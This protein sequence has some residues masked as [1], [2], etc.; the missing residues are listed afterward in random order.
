[1]HLF[2]ALMFFLLFKFALATHFDLSPGATKC[3][4]TELQPESTLSITYSCPLLN[5]QRRLREVASAKSLGRP[6]ALAQDN[7]A[8]GLT[9]SMHDPE[10]VPVYLATV[11]EEHGEIDAATHELAGEHTL[12]F[13]LNVSHSWWGDAPARIAVD[14]EKAD[15]TRV[16]THLSS[17]EQLHYNAD[18]LLH[19]VNELKADCSHF[20]RSQK[21]FLERSKKTECRIFWCA[22]FQALFVL[23]LMIFQMKSIYNLIVEKKMV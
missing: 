11:A 14:Y 9:I 4:Y 1:M 10:G 21:Q 2:Y 20:A 12:C 3:F 13:S 15:Y 16:V 19:I 7:Q 22:I 23:G 8:L 18:R 6:S 17:I 5:S